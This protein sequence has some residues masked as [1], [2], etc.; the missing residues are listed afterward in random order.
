MFAS[1]ITAAGFR[2]ILRDDDTARAVY[3]EAAGVA[4]ILPR[5]V[6]VPAD[7][8]DVA[9]LVRWA[10]EHRVALVPRGSG[11]SMANGAVGDGVIV[12]LGRLVGSQPPTPGGHS[13]V[14]G[15]AVL[16]DNVQSAALKVGMQFPV[17]PSSGA[18]AT[19]GGMVAT[20]AAGSRT[21]K[22][23]PLRDW[24]LG[25]ECVF[26]DGTRAWVRRG[27]HPP[28]V[29]AV[30]EFLSSVAPRVLDAAPAAR[31]HEG[32]RKESSGYALEAFATGG[33]VL[34]LLI[35]SEGTLAIITAVEVRLTPFPAATASLLAGFR[36]LEGAVATATRLG[37]RGVSA[38]EL[39]D[40]SFLDIVRGS[41]RELPLPRDLEAVLLVEA[42][43]HAEE[44]ARQLVE[45]LAGWCYAGG[46]IHVETAMSTDEEIRLWKLRHAASPI[47]NEL[48]PRLQSMQ[49][50]EDGC[51]PSAR[52]PEYVRGV[53]AALARAGF[54]G[55]IFGHAGD[56]HAH[57][58]ALVD[59]TA[60]DWR[61]RCEQLLDEVTALVARLG[62][63]L[64]GEHGDGRL[65]T[66]LMSRH[67]PPEALALFAAVKTAFDPLGILN[68]GVKVAAPG[69]VPLGDIKYDPALAP[70]PAA[71]RSALDLVVRER[72]WARHRLDLLG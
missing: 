50:V 15:A 30:R 33:E 4:R 27:A 32:V 49:L 65:R 20:H 55:V 5:A 18:F 58:N 51:V 22:Y 60:P 21:V 7:A 9:T 25:V 67:W 34:D 59:V 13:M 66:P 14:V 29:P 63:T 61:A 28:A 17:D 43:R 12:D 56:A 44:D 2:G 39:L 54:Q 48:A 72:G 16:R 38:V 68:P 31:R 46:A 53:R 36:D 26:A 1:L 69:A 11:S 10:A 6:A 70:L 19:I 42:E 41:G 64:S 62:G 23:G 35:G 8:E 52:F 71:A 45:E 40:R 3:S 24:I 57:V 37:E 47:L